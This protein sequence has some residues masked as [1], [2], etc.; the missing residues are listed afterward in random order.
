MSTLLFQY[1]CFRAHAPLSVSSSSSSSSLSIPPKQSS[2]PQN[3]VCLALMDA[4]V[5][6]RSIFAASA[7]SLSAERRP[8]VDPDG[9][10]EEEGAAVLVRRFGWRRVRSRTALGLT[11]ASRD[12]VRT[13]RIQSSVFTARTG[14]SAQRWP[15]ASAC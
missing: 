10:E 12:S 7:V 8:M 5:P 6:M 14:M 9:Q 3:A 4:S 13:A 1:T 2:L 11:A 15:A